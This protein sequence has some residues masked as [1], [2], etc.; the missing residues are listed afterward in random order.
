MLIWEIY[1]Y[2]EKYI[3]MLIYNEKDTLILS[4]LLIDMY[5]WIINVYGKRKDVSIKYVFMFDGLAINNKCW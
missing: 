1:K 4:F 3:N 2:V 5:I